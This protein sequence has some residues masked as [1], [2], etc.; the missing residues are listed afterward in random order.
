MIFWFSGTGNSKYAAQRMA[1]ALNEPMLCMNDRIKAH[2]TAAVETGERLVIVT[3]TYAWRIPRLVRDWLLQTELRGARQAWFVMT[4]GSEIGSA[5]RYN[6]ELCR[7]K[8]LSCMGTAQIV[9]PENYIAMFGVPQADEA[10]RIVAK[11]EPDIDRAIAALR[12]GLP[13]PPT[14]NN[15]YDRLMSGPVNPIFYAC[16]VKDRAFTAGP[17]C[18]G[19]GL[20]AKRCPTNNISPRRPSSTAGRA[21]ASRAIMLR[22]CKKQINFPL[23]SG[24]CAPPRSGI[25]CRSCIAV[26]S[27][28]SGTA[29]EEILHFV[30]S[31]VEIP[32]KI[33]QSMPL[34][35]RKLQDFRQTS[36]KS[37]DSVSLH[38]R[39]GSNL[40]HGEL[41][42]IR[43]FHL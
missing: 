7:V 18:T 41:I 12:E 5:D 20:C 43:A 22:R 32:R 9:M 34:R 21:A 25:F 23:R 10:R 28:K 36:A 35:E 17:A 30:S 39:C 38:F 13:F 11:A 15:L 29:A 37:A 24:A 40:R 16:F 42:H 3:P 14:R 26:F 19:C 8:G 31:L 33:S 4:C 1:E 6:R 27:S 2:D